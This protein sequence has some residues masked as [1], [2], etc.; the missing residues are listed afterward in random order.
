SDPLSGPPLLRS[1]GARAVLVVLAHEDRNVA[2]ALEDPAGTALGPR[3]EPL[4]GRSFVHVRRTDD[5]RVL[6]ERLPGLVRLDASVG[7]RALD[8][9]AHGLGSRLRREPQHGHGLGGALPTDRVDDA[10]SLEGRDAHVSRLRLGFHRFLPYL[11]DVLVAG[12]A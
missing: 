5:E 3:P 6:V 12:F 7:D 9:L 1:S 4:E 10:P 2:R 8:D 11:S